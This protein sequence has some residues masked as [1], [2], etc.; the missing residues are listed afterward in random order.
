MYS[1]E[2]L[3]QAFR[4]LGVGPGDVVMMHASVRAVGEIAGG[5][6]EIHL[7][8]KDA[9]SAE[10]TLVMYASCPSYVDEVGR[11]NLTPAQ[12]AEVLE[13]LPPFDARTAR[14]ARDNGVLVE[15]LRT[16]PGS[17]VTDHVARF[18]AWGKHADHVCSPQPWD[19]AFGRGSALDR[20]AALDGRILLLGCDH[21][22]VTFLHYVEHIADIPDKR[23]ARFKVPVLENGRRVWKPMEEFD[24]SSSGVH[25]NWPDRFFAK[26]VDAHLS[27]SGNRGGRVGDAWCHLFSAR[28][29]LEFARPV[30]ERV[31]RDAKAADDLD[32]YS[33]APD[34]GPPKGRGEC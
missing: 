33:L 31:A 26:I 17:R 6:D 22:T 18:V 16:Y 30:M 15:F 19:Y 34:A 27:A 14:A 24:T 2:Q 9:L 4:S 21:D 8:L 11:G 1:R 10:G 28:A 29:L 12:E 3:A 20:F 23:V 13:K 32:S 25:A 7:A 5:P